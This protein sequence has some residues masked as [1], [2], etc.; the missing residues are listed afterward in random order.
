MLNIVVSRPDR[1][2]ELLPAGAVPEFP[3]DRAAT[4]W[5][6]FLNPSPTE[7]KSLSEKFAFHDLAIEDCLGDV[8]DPKIDLYE[9]YLFVV[10]HAITPNGMYSGFNKNEIDMFLGRNF[11]VSVHKQ[12]VRAIDDSLDRCRKNVSTTLS[13]GAQALMHE[14]LDHAVDELFPYMDRIQDEVDHVEDEI[15]SDQSSRTLNRIITLKRNLLHLKG[16]L[17]PQLEVIRQLSSGNYELVPKRSLI[18]FR[19]VY[20]HVYRLADTANVA[21]DLLTGSQE[22]YR[23]LVDSRTNQIM[24]TLTI[25]STL[26]LPPTLISSIYGMNF[27]HLPGA[28][29]S[30]GF[31][32]IVVFTIGLMGGMLAIFRRMKWL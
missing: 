28:D 1:P 23:I 22:T 24:K 14:I 9:G 27:R 31:I 29:S 17:G 30:F 11:I 32:G 18:Y 15:F 2:V 8:R 6:D 19:N 3:L 7:I 20:D 12:P 26:I 16:T 10:F 4:F 5:F 13:R 21:R 25:I